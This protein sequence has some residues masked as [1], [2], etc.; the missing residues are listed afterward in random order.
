MNEPELDELFQDPAQREVV[1][2]LRMSRPAAPPLD[3]NF[4]T[5]LRTKLMTEARRTLQPRAARRGFSFSLRPKVLLPAMAAVAAGFLVV[6]G[7]QVFLQNQSPSSMVALDVSHIQNKTN[8]ATGDPIVIPFSGPVDKNAVAASVVIEPA[9]SVTKQWVGQNLVIIPDHPLAPNT[10]YSVTLKPRA[11]PPT[12]DPSNPSSTPRPVPLPTPV[13]VHFTTVRAPVAPV[14]PP[15]YLSANVSYGSESRLADAGTI[16]NGGWTPSGQLLVTRP[17][18]QPGPGSLPTPSATATA[19]GPLAPKATTDIW[20]MSASGTPIRLLVP[21]GN[22]PAAAPSG[23]VFAAWQ[24]TPSDQANLGIWDLQGNWQGTIA[25][26]DGVPD[27]A[28]VWIGSDRIAYINQGRLLVVDVHGAQVNARSIKMQRGSLAGSPLGTLLAVESVDGL[29]TVIDLASGSPSPLPGLATGFAWSSK[30]DL[31]LLVPQPSG[32]DLYIAAGGKNA[33]RIAS[34]P[35][36]QTWSDL[37]WAP[38]AASLM[39]AS[40][41]VGASSSTSRLMLINADGTGLRDFASQQEDSSPQWSSHGDLVLFTR[42]DEA[43]GRAFWTANT[44]PSEVDAAARQAVAEVERFMLARLKGDRTAA[45]SSLDAAGLTAYQGGASPLLSPA[46]SKFDRYYPVTVQQTGSNPNK[47]LVGVRIF[48]SRSG[49]QRSFFEEQ[50]TLV[51]SDQRYLVDAV[52]STPSVALGHGP[53]VVSYE[54]V[55]TSQGSQVRV[56]F[57]ADLR[58]ETVTT[59][60]IQVRDSD[61]NPI[62]SQLTFDPDNHLATL[63]VTLQSRSTYQLVVT[64]GVTDINGVTMAEE[65]HAQVVGR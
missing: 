49:V 23:G 24:V 64:T 37:N 12:P 33:R 59:S 41:P 52:T 5:Y 53:T 56:H 27:R 65:Y 18:G 10:A 50:L 31:A 36:G 39:L 55:S 16:F 14:V 21:G 25:T 30:G 29:S 43:G 35:S 20:L 60:T 63:T 9:T 47:F 13:V 57:D 61:G 1:E 58:P 26:L 17:E 28:P 34:S 45:Q 62:G 54:V 11:T 19:S 46:G 42:Q 40:K 8:V 3:P 7:I 32:I 15:S 2:L 22:F 51:L 38:D 48:V 4:R 6:L 44:V